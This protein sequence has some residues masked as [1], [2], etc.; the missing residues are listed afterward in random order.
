[1]KP[2]DLIATP[3]AASIKNMVANFDIGESIPYKH[4]IELCASLET[5]LAAANAERD[6][7]KR[8]AAALQRQ[9]STAYGYGCDG[10]EPPWMK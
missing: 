10:G 4:A 2:P 3:R 7:F 6:A 1:M 8:K 9:L 5:E